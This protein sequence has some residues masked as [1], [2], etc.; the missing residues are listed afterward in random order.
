MMKSTLSVGLLATLLGGI[1]IGSQ[2]NKG[3]M[4]DVRLM[5]VDPG[6]FHAAL[7]QKEMYPGVSERVDVYAPL[8]PDLTEHLNRIVAF[9]TRSE[10]PTR[11]AM[12]VHASPDFFQ[13]M[14]RERPGN[15]VVL[16]GRNRG[17]IARI[18][19]SVQAALHVLGDKPWI[20]EADDLAKV[21]AVLADADRNGSVAYD[22]MTERF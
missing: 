22:I 5:T 16:S 8:G 15:V 19:A 21:E 9:N 17:K 3:V 2:G 10:Q 13:R 7:V 18:L 12:E 20:L 1:S 6:H 14:L 4:P 11:W